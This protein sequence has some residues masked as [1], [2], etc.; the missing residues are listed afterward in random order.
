MPKRIYILSLFLIL[1]TNHSC[2]CYSS[3]S[4]ED[5]IRGIMDEY[6]SIGLSVVAVRNDS[7]VYFST[8]GYNP[9]YND[10]TLRKPIPEN[11]VY[12]IASISKTFVST[13]IMQLVEK[14]KLL[15]DDDI[16]KYLPFSVRN[17]KYP[18][19]PITVRMLLCHRSSLNDNLYDWT[20]DQ[21]NPSTS[22]RIQE[23]F[24]D[25]APG[26][27]YKYCNLSY[28]LLGSIIENITGERFYEYVENH[29]T[30]PL[31]LTC[32][33]N[34]S[35]I[36]STLIVRALKF[37]KKKQ[38]FVMDASIYDYQYS[39]EKTENYKLGYSA[40]NFSPTGGMKISAKDLAKYMMMHMNYGKYNGQ[41]IISKKSELEMWKNQMGN[42]D[43]GLAFTHYPDM[44]RGK[45]MVGMTG[46]AHG[47]HSG[48][49]FCPEE[50]FG[51]VI[52]CNGCKTKSSV[53][54]D[55]SKKIVRILY[56]NLI[57]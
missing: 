27:E 50:K 53:G 19:V 3:G 30:E 4:I 7:I 37:S 56:K 55:M 36:D 42:T 16:N 48:M 11:G 25:Y 12:V 32:N 43:Y 10:T 45:D 38:K 23:C 57:K 22:N 1:L 46:G 26:K 40:A 51:F 29:I 13:A 52:I 35:K 33:Y 8:F 21:I 17:P 14:K 6:S 34:L 15:L 47:I 41:R 54:L 39:K 2:L 49:F 44:I 5:E 31:G 9:D 28:S 20:I 24:N 18:D